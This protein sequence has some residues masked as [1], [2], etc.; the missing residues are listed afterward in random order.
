LKTCWG[1]WNINDR[2]LW[3]FQHPENIANCESPI[4]KDF[5][6]AMALPLVIY[7]ILLILNFIE[8][9]PVIYGLWKLKL[10]W[11]HWSTVGQWQCVGTSHSAG[12]PLH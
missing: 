10:M 9:F 12:L 4:F 6:I 2:I 3:K 5:G 1:N 8:F 7:G 11:K